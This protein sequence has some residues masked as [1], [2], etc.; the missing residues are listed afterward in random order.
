M[1]RQVEVCQLRHLR[2][3]LAPHVWISHVNSVLNPLLLDLPV[4]TD[5]GICIE[6]GHCLLDVRNYN[7]INLLDSGGRLHI[8]FPCLDLLPLR[9]GHVHDVGEDRAVI[10]ANLGEDLAVEVDVSLLH[11]ADELAVCDAMQPGVCPNAHNPERAPLT[12][13]QPAG[14]V[15]LLQ[16]SHDCLT[17]L[18][19]AVA[20]PAKEM[21]GVLQPHFP[22]AKDRVH[23]ALGLDLRDDTRTAPSGT[24]GRIPTGGGQVSLDWRAAQEGGGTTADAFPIWRYGCPL[25]PSHTRCSGEGAGHGHELRPS[26]ACGFAAPTGGFRR[27][28]SG[29]IGS[30]PG[31]S[32]PLRPLVATNHCEDGSRR[33]GAGPTGGCRERRRS[34]GSGDDTLTRP[35]KAHG[36]GRRPE[37]GGTRQP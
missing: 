12:L 3:D 16:S 15:L 20:L 29:P 37:E 1:V 34:H 11:L 7:I 5:G 22:P 27:T 21:L 25:P 17:C 23:A 6:F 19:V 33:S 13:E 8:L 30:V 26:V 24:G 10:D 18:P 14:L 9:N 32:P 31:H 2:Q 28:E 36:L 4:E 35:R